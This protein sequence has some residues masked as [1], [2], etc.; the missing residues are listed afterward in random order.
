MKKYRT[1]FT[2]LIVASLVLAFI[3]FRTV[4]DEAPPPGPQADDRAG[5]AEAPPPS[6]EVAKPAPAAPDVLAGA[7]NE[8]FA[9]KPRIQKAWVSRGQSIVLKNYPGAKSANF[10][11][12]FFHRGF[13]DRAVT[14]GEVQFQANGKTIADYQ[15][16]IYVGIQSSYLETDIPNFD[17]LWNKLCVR[18]YQ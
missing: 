10:S 9:D 7:V 14:C 18:T 11:N 16:F 8:Q 6:K 2:G 1:L 5:L 13:K 12:T 4:N 15:R 3:Y 17:L